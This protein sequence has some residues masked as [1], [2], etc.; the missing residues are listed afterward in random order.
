M[1]INA[2]ALD[3]AMDSTFFIF[4][5]LFITFMVLLLAFSKDDEL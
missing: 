2:E 3:A 4:F 1:D 5:I